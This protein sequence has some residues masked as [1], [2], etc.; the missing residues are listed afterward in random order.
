MLPLDQSGKLAHHYPQAIAA[1]GLSLGLVLSWRLCLKGIQQQQSL[2]PLKIFYIAGHQR[3][4]VGQR[5]AG[6][7]G[8]PKGHL[9]LLAQG[10]CLIKDGLG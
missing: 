8:I 1:R 7:E 9:S 2:N 3:Q 6:Y 4:P 5:C 10:H